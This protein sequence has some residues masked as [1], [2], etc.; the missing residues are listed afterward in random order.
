MTII[1]AFGVNGNG[2]NGPGSSLGLGAPW[3]AG[4]IFE[5]TTSGYQLSGYGGWCADSAQGTVQSFALWQVTGATSGTLVAGSEA[6]MTGM[7]PGTWKYVSLGTPIPLTANT[8]YK[9][10]AFNPSGNGP[11][12]QNMFNAG[13]TYVNGVTNGVLN[14]FSDVAASGG[15]NPM[16]TN[17]QQGSFTQNA[18]AA[19][20]NYPTNQF[21]S[22]NPWIDVQ[23]TAVAPPPEFGTPAFIQNET[24]SVVQQWSVTT[25]INKPDTLGSAT[26]LRVLVPDSPNA[27]YP[28]SFVYTLPVNSGYH[29]TAN[30]NGLDTILALN[31]HNTYNIT[32]I[33]PA[34]GISPWYADHPTDA[35]KHLE[36]FMKDLAAWAATSSLAI[37]GSELHYLLGFS[38]SGIGGAGLLFRNPN[39]FATAGLWDAPFAM[40]AYDG[41]DPTFGSTVGGASAV[42]YGTDASFQANYRLST[43]NV[44]AWKAA[45]NFGTVNRLWIGGS[46]AFAA[47]VAAFKSELTSLGVLYTGTWNTTGDSHAWHNN[48]VDNA[49]LTILPLASSSPV[50]TLNP[51]TQTVAAGTNVTLLSAATGTPTPTVQWQSSPDGTTWTNITGATTG[52]LSLT[53]VAHGLSGTRYRAVFTNTAGTADSQ[54]ATL[55]VTAPNVATV[56]MTFDLDALT[57]TQFSGVVTITAES[58]AI[59][60]NGIL[61][62]PESLVYDLST[63]TQ[64]DPMLGSDGSTPALKYTVIVEGGNAPAIVLVHQILNSAASPVSLSSLIAG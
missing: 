45:S 16:P 41:T 15:T 37:S 53:N 56:I 11:W 14:V 20:V 46:S 19:D 9:I 58:P 23:I 7:T 21:D 3:T 61:W 38:K 57:V 29:D 32:V 26:G 4:L 59:D 13:G 6:S 27:A 1:S 55:T 12:Q 47:D 44:T 30:G 28:H 35:T 33:E 63:A 8:V 24:S 64:S 31:A 25:T 48:W 50:V 40:T 2:A 17:A 18:T 43:A 39:V 60:G 36:T 5:V 42:N 51:A 62:M 34:F 10:V 49:L 54:A 22:A 52:T